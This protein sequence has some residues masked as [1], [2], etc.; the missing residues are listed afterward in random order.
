MVNSNLAAPDLPMTYSCSSSGV[1]SP[2]SSQ[3]PTTVNP[4]PTLP[5]ETAAAKAMLLTVGDFPAGWAEDT[6]STSSSNSELDKCST[7][8]TEGRTANVKTGTFS[9]DGTSPIN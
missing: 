2:P 5:D 4:T 9:K 7:V 6:S 1:T 3:A 8:S